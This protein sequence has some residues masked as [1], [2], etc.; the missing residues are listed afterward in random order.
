MQIY[1]N[2]DKTHNRNDNHVQHLNERKEKL[3]QGMSH[4]CLTLLQ[5]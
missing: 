2:D 4:T 1:I 5:Q 3:V